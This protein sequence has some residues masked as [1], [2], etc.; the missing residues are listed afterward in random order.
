MT[1]IT[2]ASIASHYI[3]SI[4]SLKNSISTIQKQ[5]ASGNLV[6]R[7]SDSPSKAVILIRNNEMLNQIN[8][9]LNNIKTGLSF[10]NQTVF[11]L[12]VIQSELLQIIR[13]L[14]DIEDPLK[15]KNLNNYADQL[16]Q[17]LRMIMDVA[18]SKA[19]GR[20]V[21]GGT[22]L[23][24]V[25]FKFSNDN[26]TI[27]QNPLI[28][29]NVNVKISSGL[30]Q[31]INL[32][33]AEVF[34]TILYSNGS[35]DRNAAI[36]TI[37]TV[38][39]NIYDN[40]GNQYT[41]RMRFEKV[42]PNKYSFTYQI[43]DSNNNLVHSSSSSNTLSFDPN[44]GYLVSINNKPPSEINI[45]VPSNR[46]N[47][48]I[49]FQNTTEGNSLNFNFNLNQ[50]TDIFN[51]LQIIIR[52]LRNGV[53]P[54]EAQKA[55]VDKFHIRVLEKLSEVG[56]IVNQFNSFETMLNQYSLEIQTLNQDVVGVDVVK[57]IID[58]QNK[59]YLLQVTQKIAAAILP[60]SL[61]DYL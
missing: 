26:Q 55:E 43:L 10:L 32:S 13:K 54:T 17:S 46:I 39:Q 48:Y 8:S 60:K 50:Q 45:S 9:N 14:T 11:S 19:E 56:N 3:K 31:R 5:I 37:S 25:P 2:E 23:S 29:G 22:D 28:K 42:E 52:N 12:E 21:F 40:F 33:G 58:L 7:P 36:G 34:S 61:L 1:R 4:N 16:E 59:D 57:S 30:T 6:S 15:Q 47:F 53:L 44:S 35:F 49:D 27:E 24:D 51:T 20:Y 18:N 38:D 41:F